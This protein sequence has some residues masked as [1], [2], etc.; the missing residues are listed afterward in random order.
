L[1]ET[2]K[3]FFD[4]NLF[5]KHLKK[6]GFAPADPRKMSAFVEGLYAHLNQVS[7]PLHGTDPLILAIF[8]E[9][10]FYWLKIGEK[11]AG[12]REKFKNVAKQD[13]QEAVSKKSRVFQE[14]RKLLETVTPPTFLAERF[15]NKMSFVVGFTATE[16]DKN[17]SEQDRASTSASSSKS[18]SISC[19][20]G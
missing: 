4:T 6:Y 10:D 11:E 14:M 19:H 20:R 13:V 3:V 8:T 16:T 15:H 1:P 2:K 18:L 7:H 12:L 9:E 5:A 17:V